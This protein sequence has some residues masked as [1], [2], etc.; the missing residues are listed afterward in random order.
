MACCGKMHR[1]SWFKHGCFGHRWYHQGW[2]GLVAL[3]NGWTGH[4]QGARPG[5]EI[6]C[7]LYLVS[8]F[9][10]SPHIIYTQQGMLTH[11]QDLQVFKCFFRHRPSR[12]TSSGHPGSDPQMIADV[13][14]RM[15]RIA[16]RRELLFAKVRPSHE[17]KRKTSKSGSRT[18]EEKRSGRATAACGH[19]PA[20]MFCRRMPA[21]I[22]SF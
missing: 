3:V 16:G 11:P 2:A 1:A 22:A 19:G 4:C 21:K 15:L 14:S 17:R 20:E 5:I 8:T 7:S 10:F 13:T 6:R 12:R 18:S 9:L